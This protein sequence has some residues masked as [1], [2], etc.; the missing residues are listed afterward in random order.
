MKHLRAGIALLITASALS[1]C[2]VDSGKSSGEAGDDCER[3]KGNK[4][5]V[6]YPFNNLPLYGS[7]KSVVE[8]TA[9]ERGYEVV[10]TADN[11]NLDQQVTA[12]ESLV[13]QQVPAIVTLP[14]E[15]TAVEPILARAREN[16]IAVVTYATSLENEDANIGLNLE[17]SGEMLAQD[18]VDWA[19]EEGIKG[20]VLIL[21]NNDLPAG[22]A[23]HDGILRVLE[24]NSDIMT[25]VSDQKAT[26]PEGATSAAQ[27]V[28]QGNKDINIVLGFSDDWALAG[29]QA[30][31]NLDR[32]VSK[33]SGIYVGGVDAAPNALEE[34][35]EDTAYRATVG[36]SLEHD[37]GSMATV[38]ADI[39]DGK[40]VPAVTE[41]EVSLLK[42][43]QPEVQEWLDQHLKR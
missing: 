21:N 43:G 9:D 7:L 30:M 12:L 19:E 18:A 3:P 13:A 10:W 23:R 37:A 26:T 27:Q 16:C 24:E 14:L 36:S 17:L 42:P 35:L 11:G 38:P 34:L 40:D 25:V 29:Y 28:L 22:K 33:E 20:K 5:A 4:I 39:L 15:P 8:E 1:A 6:D 32:D 31:R 2:S 41:L